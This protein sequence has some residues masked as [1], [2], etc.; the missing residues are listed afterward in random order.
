VGCEPQIMATTS[1]DKYAAVGGDMQR[2]EYRTF[3]LVKRK[4]ESEELDQLGLQG[5][6]AVGMVSSWGLGWR[7]VHPIVLFKRP[8]PNER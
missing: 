3:D 8:L 2:W 7:M 1:E 6:E 4:N 5:W